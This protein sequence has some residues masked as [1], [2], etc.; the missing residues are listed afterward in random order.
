MR[1]EFKF[2]VSSKEILCRMLRA[3]DRSDRRF[4]MSDVPYWQNRNIAVGQTTPQQTAVPEI[5][6]FF[7]KR[8]KLQH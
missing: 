6:S 3:S 2:T 8:S 4:Y 1:A 5:L 7:K